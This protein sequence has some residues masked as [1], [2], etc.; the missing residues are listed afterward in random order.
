MA[1]SLDQIKAVLDEKGYEFFDNNEKYN[2]NI[3]SIRKDN[4]VPDSFDDELYL[5]YRDDDVSMQVQSFPVTT[6]PGLKIL[7][8]P[9]TAKGTAILVPNQYR[10]THIIRKHRGK[11]DAV[12]QERPVTVWR[13]D[14]KDEVLDFNNINRESGRFG[15]NIHRSNPQTES[16][17]V[18]GWSAGC[19][20]FKRVKDFYFFMKQAYKTRETFGNSFSYTL[21]TEQ[22]FSGMSSDQPE[23]HD[24]AASKT[25]KEKKAA[26][27]IAELNAQFMEILNVLD[28]KK[29]AKFLLAERDGLTETVEMLLKDLKKCEDSPEKKQL[30][31]ELM[32]EKR[33]LSLALSWYKQQLQA[34]DTL[35]P[36]DKIIEFVRKKNEARHKRLSRLNKKVAQLELKQNR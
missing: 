12:C 8:K 31:E 20:V 14:N 33:Q 13:D 35:P 32:N 30:I 10:G 17:I 25:E 21:L 23:T 18:G 2:L 15:I 9:V 34:S 22:D 27:E 7:L 5:V 1:Y 26:K 24:P 4:K 19:T 16:T 6:D 28:D 3:I 36:T 29:L 11:Y